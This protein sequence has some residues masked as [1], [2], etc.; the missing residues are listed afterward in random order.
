MI[1]SAGLLMRYYSAV[2]SQLIPPS[3]PMVRIS[4]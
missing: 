4:Q 3:R 2:D 1:E